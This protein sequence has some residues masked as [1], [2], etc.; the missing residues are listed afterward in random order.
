M[1]SAVVESWER[2]GDDDLDQLFSVYLYRIA[3]WSHGQTEMRFTAQDIGIFKSIPRPNSRSPS[4]RH[5][6]AAQAAIPMLPSWDQSARNAR[7]TRFQ[8][9]AP[10]PA[11]R[12][13][14]ENGD[15]HASGA[16][17]AQEGGVPR[18]MGV[19]RVLR[20]G[21]PL[22]TP[23]AEGIDTCPSSTWRHSSTTQTS[24]QARSSVLR[25]GDFFVRLYPPRKPCSSTVPVDRHSGPRRQ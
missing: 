15:V 14:F 7:R 6:L 12:A 19:V 5:D 8:L 9:D 20:P 10:V 11:G 3:Q 25:G 4:A 1:L 16:E 17:T 21:D 13:F 22:G 18:E 2:A 23:V 24:S